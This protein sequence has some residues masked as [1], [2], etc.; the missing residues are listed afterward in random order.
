MFITCFTKI[1]FKSMSQASHFFHLLML[2]AFLVLHHG[3][4]SHNHHPSRKRLAYR[5]TVLWSSVNSPQ[6]SLKAL[7]ISVGFLPYGGYLLSQWNCS[8]SKA[9]VF[10]TVCGRVLSCNRT[11][12]RESLPLRQDNLRFHR[13]AEIK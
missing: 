10:Q 6:S 3:L 9:C 8:C 5:E 11:T 7:W 4:C 13:S 1:F 2:S 12:P